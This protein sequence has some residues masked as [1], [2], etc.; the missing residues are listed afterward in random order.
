MTS[1]YHLRSGDE[2]IGSLPCLDLEET[3]TMRASMHKNNSIA[4]HCT[5][6]SELMQWI[7]GVCLLTIAI[8]SNRRAID[9]QQMQ[10]L[11]QT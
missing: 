9:N 11:Y 5:P 8:A 1:S 2:M 10:S 3:L 4:S 6:V 7:S